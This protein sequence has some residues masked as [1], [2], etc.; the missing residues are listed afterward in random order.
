MEK[1]IEAALIIAAFILGYL[2]CKVRYRV[3]DLMK[4]IDLLCGLM[5]GKLTNE[6]AKV[7]YREIF[8]ED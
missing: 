5:S 1:I 7:K 6:E 4:S 2:Y 3:K 8:P